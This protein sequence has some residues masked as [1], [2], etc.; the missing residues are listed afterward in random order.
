MSTENSTPTPAPPAPAAATPTPTPGPDSQ[1][2]SRLVAISKREREIQQKMDAFKQ[3]KQGMVAKSDLSNLWKSDR[4]K[5]RE[6]LG[7]SPEELP[8]LQTAAPDP[9]KSLKEEL[10]ALKQDKQQ[11][12]HARAVKEAKQN[13]STFLDSDK[14]AYELIHAFEGTDM[15]FDYMV[16]HYKEH[17]ES[18]DFKTAAEHVE[19]HLLD[20]LK[21]VTGTKKATTLFP[22]SESQNKEP[23]PTLTGA[24]VSSPTSGVKRSLSPEESL[25]EAAK[26]LVWK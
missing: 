10:D 14:D 1:L 4:S 18:L 8:D 7:A 11:E 5:L 25:A 24:T 20:Q 12:N 17:Q 15:V 2:D 3:E 9:Y 22:K 16:D 13:L 21:R 23:A 26:L 19:S 6:L